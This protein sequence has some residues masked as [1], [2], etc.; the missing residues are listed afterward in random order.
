MANAALQEFWKSSS[1]ETKININRHDF[2]W[3]SA[4]HH[5]WRLTLVQSAGGQTVSSGNGMHVI[6]DDSALD[7]RPRWNKVLCI[8]QDENAIRE[9]RTDRHKM[10][11]N[12]KSLG[13]LESHSHALT[14]LHPTLHF[15]QDFLPAGSWF[16]LFQQWWVKWLWTR[17]FC[18]H[19]FD[20]TLNLFPVF[21]SHILGWTT[22]WGFF[23]PNN[24]TTTKWSKP[25]FLK[26]MPL[27][28]CC[29][30]SSKVNIQHK[31]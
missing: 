5:S 29:S 16:L 17:T 30:C 13:F 27:K 23:F 22:H 14:Q 7:G 2:K 8:P 24:T 11:A 15:G 28:N 31:E 4:Y 10:R 6:S 9:P 1:M 12:K 3:C 20:T 19:L 25:A 18:V 26:M 21:R